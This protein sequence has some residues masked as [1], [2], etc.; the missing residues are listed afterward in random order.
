MVGKG[1]QPRRHSSGAIRGLHW[2]ATGSIHPALPP[3]LS[4]LLAEPLLLYSPTP[5]CHPLHVGPTST[6]PFCPLPRA[7]H[8][9]VADACAYPRRHAGSFIDRQ[10]MARIDGVS[11]PL[12]PWLPA[13]DAS[14]AFRHAPSA[15]CPPAILLMSTSD[16][17][18]SIDTPSLFM[19]SLSSSP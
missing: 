8:E 2:A 9:I 6:P 12:L 4:A 7:R 16:G 3:H 11:P 15:A 10:G 19:D 14:L 5:F 17:P 18:C 13:R 1:C